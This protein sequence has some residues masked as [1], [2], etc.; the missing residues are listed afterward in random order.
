MATQD[1]GRFIISLGF[2]SKTLSFLFRVSV[3][4]R[5]I[6][7]PCKHPHQP[8]R[9]FVQA[10]GTGLE[11]KCILSTPISFKPR[12]EPKKHIEDIEEKS[13]GETWA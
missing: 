6:C 8:F 13:T 2:P 9:E 12:L 4:V 3:R 10:K 1:I 11:S 5:F 7:Q